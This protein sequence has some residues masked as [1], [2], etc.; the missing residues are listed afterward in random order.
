MFKIIGY[1]VVNVLVILILSNALPN[2][3]VANWQ[4]ATIFLVV[5]ALLNWT[6]VPI[7]KFLTFP[8]NFLTLGIVFGLINLLA[9]SL[10]EYLVDGF[11]VSGGFWSK[12]FTYLIIALGLSIGH[13]LVENLFK[14]DCDQD[15]N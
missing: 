3:E 1:L 4:A 14:K 12:F 9:L 5:L 11:T 15:E 10:T 7:V 13:N 6:I 8:L 2:F